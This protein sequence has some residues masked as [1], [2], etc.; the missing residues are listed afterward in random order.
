VAGTY[1]GRPVFPGDVLR[2][3]LEVI[4][5][6]LSR[7]RSGLGLLEMVGSAHRGEDCVLQMTFTAMFAT[8]T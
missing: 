7:S 3:R 5:A 2:R 1:R 8:R 4:G 6:R